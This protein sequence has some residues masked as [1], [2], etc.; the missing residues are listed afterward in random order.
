MWPGSRPTCVPSGIL[1][2]P[3]VWPQYMG[4]KVGACCAPFFFRGAGTHL[5][6]CRLSPRLLPYQVASWSIQPYGRNRHGPKIEGAVP[7]LGRETG[8]PSNTISRGRG[9]PPC[10]HAKWDLDTSKRLSTIHQR[11]RQTGQGYDS[12]ERTVS[13]TQKV[14]KPKIKN[15]DAQKKRP[16][17]KV[18]GVSPEAGRESIVGKTCERGRFPGGTETLGEFW[19]VKVVVYAMALCL[20]ASMSATSLSFIKNISSR[21]RRPET[22]CFWRQ[23]TYSNVDAK[24]HER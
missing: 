14:K 20:S 23:R 7:V 11:Y 5:T 22:L 19:T 18:R 8:S 16:S 10:F 9:L 6:H 12:I 2:H 4:R 1:I 15:R 13:Q 21:K 24:R 3:A 17:Q